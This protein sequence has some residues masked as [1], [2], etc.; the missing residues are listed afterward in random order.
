MADDKRVRWDRGVSLALFAQL[1]SPPPP[2]EPGQLIHAYYICSLWNA[3]LIPPVSYMQVGPTHKA[4]YL[5]SEGATLFRYM[6][7]LELTAACLAYPSP[8]A[9][10]WQRDTSRQTMIGNALQ[11]CKNCVF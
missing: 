9:S 5:P 10:I 11:E 1:N 7:P 4:L 8:V 2:K 6:P 3:V